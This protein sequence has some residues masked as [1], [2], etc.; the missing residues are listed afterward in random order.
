MTEK[1]ARQQGMATI[2]A[3]I[4][5]KQLNLEETF[6]RWLGRHMKLNR[7]FWP[8]MSSLKSSTN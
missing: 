1:T 8:A 2:I 7:S 5:Y 4:L 6:D 3:D